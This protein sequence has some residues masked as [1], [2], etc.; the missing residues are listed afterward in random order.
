MVCL[1]VKKATTITLL[2]LFILDLFPSFGINFQNS[3]IF[4]APQSG[5]KQKETCDVFGRIVDKKLIQK[6]IANLKKRSQRVVVY[7]GTRLNSLYIMSRAE[8]RQDRL[9]STDEA[10]RLGIPILSGEGAFGSGLQVSEKI[11]TTEH[12][13][14]AKTYATNFGFR[15]VKEVLSEIM[16]LE[17][18]RSNDKF[19]MKHERVRIQR[20]IEQ[21]RN[22][23]RTLNKF[24]SFSQEILKDNDVPIIFGISENAFTDQK[25]KFKHVPGGNMEIRVSNYISLKN[26]P[27]VYVEKEEHIQKAKKY[28]TLIGYPNIEVSLFEEGNLEASVLKEID[29]FL[30]NLTLKK[31]DK[32]IIPYYFRLL[33]NNDIISIMEE[34][35]S[36]VFDVQK[37]MNDFMI[38][39]QELIA[40]L[41]SSN[42]FDNNNDNEG[43]EETNGTNEDIPQL[44]QDITDLLKGVSNPIDGITAILDKLEGWKEKGLAIPV[45]EWKNISDIMMQRIE[46]IKKIK[47][48]GMTFKA[49][50]LAGIGALEIQTKFDA[51]IQ[52][53]MEETRQVVAIFQGNAD[54]TVGLIAKNSG[55]ST[56]KF[57][58]PKLLAISEEILSKISAAVFV[59]QI[60]PLLNIQAFSIG[61][62]LNLANINQGSLDPVTNLSLLKP[63][64]EMIKTSSD[65][66][67]SGLK[68]VFKRI[69]N[70][71][72]DLIP[73]DMPLPTIDQHRPNERTAFST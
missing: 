3:N 73:I 59:P 14:R 72:M 12:F 50:T 18:Q 49:K 29:S 63:I 52:S 44:P 47:E 40:K 11:S 4:L 34:I 36:G 25:E 43:I 53:L 71:A 56:T 54:K 70:R 41:R 66:E 24:D 38:R 62:Q 22:Y 5:F 28:L 17:A 32:K 10:I 2:I 57:F 68:G 67:R 69:F 15:E 42:V 64:E 60:D 35:L 26:I 51:Q 58:D 30:L 6:V 48:A 61:E 7:H 31:G 21:K 13:D 37:W 19:L 20:R 9:I 45:L 33:T 46:E 55:L 65:K 8:Y 1:V 16:N 39:V 27:V 23:L